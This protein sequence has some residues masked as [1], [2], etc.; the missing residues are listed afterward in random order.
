[1][2]PRPWDSYDAYLFDIDGTL[3][4]CSDAVHY[5]AFC[6]A[7]T[8]IAGRPVNLD[9]V[10]THGSVDNAI[11]RDAFILAAVPEDQWR[12]RLAEARTL[13]CDQVTRHRADLRIDVLPGA[14]QLLE[15]LRAKGKI[16][17][18]ATGNF[19][20]IGRAKLA[21]AGLLDFFHFGGYSD[22][23]ETRSGVFASAVMQARSLTHSNA[24]I[25]VF[26]D[27]PADI[28]AAQANA[29]DI[30]AVATG[31]FPFEALA[32]LNPTRTLHT[33]TELLPVTR[34]NS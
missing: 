4:N 19:A 12:P 15:H 13:M 34:R 17:G 9:G 26:G 6:D 10:M 2:T 32:A 14:V 7:L 8:H 28:Q 23:F 29:L 1:M 3:L 20:E 18:V 27:T 21:H 24:R 5:F 16:L 31:T 33:L 11:L 25:C 22:A 30:I